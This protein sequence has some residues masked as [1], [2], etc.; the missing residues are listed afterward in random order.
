M[1]A[2]RNFALCLAAIGVAAPASAAGEG[3][4]YGARDPS[5][6]VP[7]RKTAAPSPAQAVEL[8]RCRREGVS[9]GRLSLMKDVKVRLGAGRPISSEDNSILDPD[10]SRQVHDLKGS[11]TWSVCIARDV[12]VIMGQDPDLNCTET[13]YPVATGVCWF[14]NKG[15][16]ACTLG[17]Y[18]ESEPRPNMPPVKD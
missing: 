15:E 3:T 11:F 1:R 12:A 8:I 18:S 10:I 9:G 17:G 6:C 7:L 4:A 14:T 5:V 2:I 16:W 13:D